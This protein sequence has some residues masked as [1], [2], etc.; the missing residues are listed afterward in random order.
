MKAYQADKAKFEANAENQLYKGDAESKMC[1]RDSSDSAVRN[2]GIRYGHGL[3]LIAYTE[4]HHFCLA[5]GFR[6]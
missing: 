4:I 5:T 1:I 3:A 2:K 6:Q